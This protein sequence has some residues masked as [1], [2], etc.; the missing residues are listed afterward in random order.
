MIASSPLFENVP[1]EEVARFLGSARRRAFRKGEVVFHEGDPGD[2]LHIIDK[3]RFAVRVTTLYGT[4]VTLVVLAAGD[5]F[6][7]MALLD[8]DAIR[9]ATVIALEAGETLSIRRTEFH[10]LRKNHPSV[11]E[12]LLSIL[13]YKVRRYTEQLVE[14]LYVPAE[15]RVIRRLLELANLYG[16]GQDNPT[17]PLGQEDLAGLAGTSRATVNRVL[18]KEEQRKTVRLERGRT[19]I[20]DRPALERR[21]K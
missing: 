13:T 20:L 6:G 5:I 4:V 19:T 11:T 10:N 8:E 2:T 7:E 12:V 15:V 14:A 17:V 16:R 3:G 18:R 1:L 9:G 21:A